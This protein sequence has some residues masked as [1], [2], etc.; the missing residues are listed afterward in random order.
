MP[1]TASPE[2][3]IRAATIEDAHACGLICYDAFAAIS[4]AH[5]FPCD[6]P[7]PE[8]GIGLLSMMFSA[9]GFYAVVAESDGRIV[10]S[11]V[12]A[13]QA[14]IYG[15]G[16][17]TIDPNVQNAGVGRKL[18]AAV[19]DRAERNGAAGV[20]LVQAAYHS[21]SLSLYASLGF[22][23]REPLACLQGKTRERSVPG[24]VVRHAEPADEAACNALAR[25]V[26]GVDRGVELAHAI[27]EGSARVVEREN[28][29]TGYSTHLGFFGHSTAETN[30]DMQALLASVESFSGPGVLVPSRNSALLRWCLANGLRVV[31]T[32]TLMSTGLYNEPAGAW[33]PSIVF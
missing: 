14:V 13:E 11:N 26:H 15:V 30:V 25:R 2:I 3:T 24:C 31:Q 9:P 32:M 23:V 19:M 6:L 8:V 18:M 27:R 12:L 4:A 5:G 22:D 20:R 1:S 29:V 7:S 10:G 16:P 28:R 17:I 33:L 21:R